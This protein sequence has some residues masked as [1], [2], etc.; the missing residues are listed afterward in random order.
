MT[1]SK[2]SQRPNAN[3]IA[4]KTLMRMSSSEM[5]LCIILSP[6]LEE[7]NIFPTSQKIEVGTKNK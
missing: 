4:E 5:S 7:K 1:Y 3:D 2:E 6:T